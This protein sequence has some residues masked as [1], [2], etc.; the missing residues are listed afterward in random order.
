MSGNVG[1]YPL[2]PCCSH[3]LTTSRLSRYPLPPCRS[4]ASTTYVSVLS[5]HPHTRMP[6]SVGR[7]PPAATSPPPQ[8]NIPFVMSQ[9]SQTNA[10]FVVSP[11]S[12]TNAFV[13]ASPLPQM[14]VFFA[15]LPLSYM[16][17][18]AM[19][20]PSL[21]IFAESPSSRT[22]VVFTPLKH[23]SQLHLLPPCQ[24]HSSTMRS[25]ISP[26]CK[27]IHPSMLL[28]VEWQH[29][30]A[31]SLCASTCVS[32]FLQYQFSIPIDKVSSIVVPA[33]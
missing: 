8:T 2:P 17:T 22:K 5:H 31:V 32:C 26:L 25:N 23:L 10:F 29:P 20:S 4:R 16:N 12:Q 6:S 21:N 15:V 28:S 24:T 33:V 27:H 14:N 30:A 1:R 11:L 9:P 7:Q 13:I 3:A 18:F 19:S